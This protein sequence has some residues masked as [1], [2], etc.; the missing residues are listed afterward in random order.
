MIGRARNVPQGELSQFGSLY[1]RDVVD[2]DREILPNDIH[3]SLDGSEK[4]AI[5]KLRVAN[6]LQYLTYFYC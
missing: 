5:L 2:I 1:L 6:H 4:V 3:I